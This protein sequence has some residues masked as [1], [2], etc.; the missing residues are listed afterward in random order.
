MPRKETARAFYYVFVMSNQDG[1]K[2]DVV[3]LSASE[4]RADRAFA[5]ACKAGMH[6]PKVFEVVM[7]RGSET[8]AHVTIKH[9]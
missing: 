4:Y 1:V 7:W 5:R 9:S 8:I 2:A 3:H 6:N